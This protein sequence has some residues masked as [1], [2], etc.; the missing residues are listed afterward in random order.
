MQP[1][2]RKLS[3]LISFWFVCLFIFPIS[4]CLFLC[5]PDCFSPNSKCSSHQKAFIDFAVQ[6]LSSFNNNNF[7]T[8]SL[9]LVKLESKHFKAC[10]KQPNKS[11]SNYLNSTK[12]EIYGK[13]KFSNIFLIKLDLQISANWG[14][15]SRFVLKSSLK[16][17]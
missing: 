3:L 6:V 9:K 14:T 11:V 13:R 8:S 15:N 16:S 2:L 4:F 12:H 1:I 5:I 17:M 7:D 10:K